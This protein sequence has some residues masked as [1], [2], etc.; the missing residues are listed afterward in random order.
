MSLQTRLDALI[1]R[2]GTEFKALRTIVGGSGTSDLTAINPTYTAT[3]IA[4]A[5]LEVHTIASS[6]G[7]ADTD[8]LPEGSVNLYYTDARADARVQAAIGTIAAP[9]ATQVASTQ[10]VSDHVATEIA[11]VINAAPGALDTLDELAAA[12]GDDANFATTMT[13]ALATKLDFGAAQTLT[14]GQQTQGQDNLQVYSRTE[15]GDPETD[16]VALFNAALL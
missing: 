2:I 6:G 8:A 14:A 5:L 1:T 15:L 9:S 16:L 11:A 7:P 12:L 10:N 4:A 3:D 13:T